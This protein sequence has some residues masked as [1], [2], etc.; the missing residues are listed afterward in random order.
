MSNKRLS[1]TPNTRASTS[2]GAARCSNVIPETSTSVLPIP[3]MP[4]RTSANTWF[5]HTATSAIGTPQMKMPSPKSAARRRRPTSAAAAIAPS[6]PPTPT[7]ELRK[8][9]PA[10]PVS[11]SLSAT[12]TISTFSIPSTNVCAEKSP[13]RRRRRRSR[14]IVRNPASSSS[15]TETASRSAASP[16]ETG[17]IPEIRKADQ[18]KREAVTT[19]TV[20]GP[21]AASRMPP[22]AGPPKMPTLS[23]ELAA[24]F[25]AVSSSGVRASVGTRAACAGRNA[26]AA[27]PTAPAMT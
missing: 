4:S 20:P 16:S 19:K 24:T 17:R 6:R 9:T 2:S 13:T 15:T 18:S 23:I 25:A 5:G 1:S 27:I 3:T 7:A 21:V 22:M 12:T 10:L 26:V 8:P 14:A 11:S